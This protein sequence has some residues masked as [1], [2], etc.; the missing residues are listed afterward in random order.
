MGPMAGKIVTVLILLVAFSSVF[1]ATLGYSRIP[2]AAAVDG[3]FFKPFAKL[4]PKGNFPY[5]S[6]LFLGGIAFVFSLIFKL[7]EVISAILA[8]R[9]LVQFI[10][11]AVGLLM[12]RQKRKDFP[13]KMPFYPWPVYI[14]I[15]MWCVILA[16]TGYQM[17]LGGLLFALLGVAAYYIKQRISTAGGSS[18]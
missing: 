4:H 12:L 15:A 16:S 17:V 10:G 8:M 3:A 2:Y 14:A 1:S 11:Q 9:I 7:S 5:V 6:V 13:F 18:K